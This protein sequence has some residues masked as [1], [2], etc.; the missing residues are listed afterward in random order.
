MTE[1]HHRADTWDC[2]QDVAAYALGALD[3]VEV[4]VF[5]SHLDSCAVCRDELDAFEGVVQLLPM[6]VAPHRASPQLRRR[7]MDA[8]GDQPKLEF[9]ARRRHR[10][11]PLL[12][13]LA[14]PRLGL[15]LGGALVLLAIAFAGVELGTSGGEHTRVYAAVV[16]GRGSAAVTVTGSH[17]ELVVQ[18]FSP[19]PAGQ[20]YE[21]WLGRPGNPPSPTSALFSVTAAGNADVDVPGTLRG[22]N[23]VMVTPEPAGGS[24]VPTHPAVIL[25]RLS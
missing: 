5:R 19:P 21:V 11:T 24:L 17:A 23:L 1:T 2:G 6:A 13:R 16:S 18:H 20:I 8:V 3:P 10:A 25:A 9:R 4:A 12:T 22:V 14:R 15:A 7:V